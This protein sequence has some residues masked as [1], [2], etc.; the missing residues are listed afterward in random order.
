MYPVI[1][2]QRDP[3]KIQLSSTHY[4]DSLLIKV[5][6]MSASWSYNKEKLVLDDINFEVNEV[7]PYTY[8]ICHDKSSIIL[9]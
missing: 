7:C 4:T 5:S 2:I 9:M 6:G 3:E 8:L 1:N